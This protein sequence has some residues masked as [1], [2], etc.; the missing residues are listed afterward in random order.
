MPVRREDVDFFFDD[1]IKVSTG[2]KESSV[3]AVGSYNGDL[4][5]TVVRKKIDNLSKEDIA[6]ERNFVT[7][8]D[9]MKF[10]PYRQYDSEAIKEAEIIAKVRMS[11]S[12]TT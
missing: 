5:M 9:L 7:L 2:S 12:V 8:S 4:M 1:F 10:D 6:K 3:W 11:A